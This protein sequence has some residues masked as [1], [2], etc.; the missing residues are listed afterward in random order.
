MKRI[1]KKQ[2]VRTGSRKGKKG[3]FT[4]EASLIFP[5]ICFL[6]AV[7]VQTVLYLH[8]TS[9]FVSAAYE[10]AQKSAAWRNSSQR[11]MELFAEKEVKALLE[12]RRLA[13]SSYRVEAQVTAE[14]VQV[15]IEGST[16]FLQ[17]IS[18]SAEKEALR[19]NPV[20][21]LRMR[22]KIED[23]QRCY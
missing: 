8:D 11:E 21:S 22:K 14:K 19:I 10:A 18:F 4:V 15:R 9:I 3:S 13:C 2:G 5:F 6:L 17:G 7:F 1:R 20:D 12:N 23:L 16:D